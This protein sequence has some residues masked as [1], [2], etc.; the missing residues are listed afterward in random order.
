VLSKLVQVVSKAKQVKRR[1]TRTMEQPSN[2][3]TPGA[4]STLPEATGRGHM[5]QARP[6]AGE[7][8]ED[9]TAGKVENL[10][11]PNKLY[12]RI[13]EVA[14][15]AGIKPYVLRFWETEFPGLGP[16]KSGTGHRLY[17]RKDVELVLE[18][19]HLLYEKR[20]TIEGAR[21]L[22]ASKPRKTDARIPRK[23]TEQGALF[24]APAEPSK[25]AL[26][27]VRRELGSL[28]QLLSHEH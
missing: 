14:K 22:L 20:F 26:D 5:R 13:G 7:R 27:E 19:K 11:I 23:S 24:V 16:Q 1:T 21:K 25:A 15:L 28:L 18:I 8:A 3:T 9:R 12:F 6:P 4:E 10:E 17:R 2:H